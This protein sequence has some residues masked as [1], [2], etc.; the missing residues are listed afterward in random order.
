MQMNLQL[1]KK[2]AIF[3]MNR[4]CFSQLIQKGVVLLNIDKNTVWP[5]RKGAVSSLLDLS[6]VLWKCRIDLPVSSCRYS[7]GDYMARCFHIWSKWDHIIYIVKLSYSQSL[8]HNLLHMGLLCTI[9]CW[10]HQTPNVNNLLKS[11][12]NIVDQYAKIF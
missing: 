1:K 5:W 12:G 8:F 4:L 11:D 6:N 2:C 7:Y 10:K 3:S 9:G